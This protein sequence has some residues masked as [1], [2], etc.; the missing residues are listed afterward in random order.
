MSMSVFDRQ[1]LYT[2]L[3]KPPAMKFKDLEAVMSIVKYSTLP[4]QVR[5]DLHSRHRIER[6]DLHH[7][8]VRPPRSP[9]QTEGRSLFRRRESVRRITTMSRRPVAV[10]EEAISVDV[11]TELLQQAVAGSSIISASSRWLPDATG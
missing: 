2:D 7:H 3:Q 10:F 8:S 11:P 1:K 6:T 5:A 4:M 9:V